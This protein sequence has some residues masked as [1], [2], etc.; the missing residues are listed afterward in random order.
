[1]EKALL[2]VKSELL[3]NRE[4]IIEMGKQVAL[5]QRAARYLLKYKNKIK[6]A[7][8]DSLKQYSHLPFQSYSIS[9][10]ND[11]M[12]MLKSSGLIQK[13][14]DKKLAIQIIKT[15]SGIKA[16]Y[17]YFHSFN[18]IKKELQDDFA[19]VP[20]I[21]RYFIES[22]V[23]DWDFLFKHLEAVALVNQISQIQ[24][25][26]AYNLLKFLFHTFIYLVV[27]FVDGINGFINRCYILIISFD[28]L[29]LWDLV[30]QRNGFQMFK[31][32]IPIG[33]VA[34]YKITFDFRNGGEVIL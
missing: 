2:L 3:I 32:K 23:T 29:Y 13:I 30:N 25:V 20:E 6:E 21:K 16:A 10:V 1:M 4:Q 24:N 11:A 9:I 27:L 12:E 33:H 19:A 7:S 8:Q 5:E 15:Y 34:F 14:N 26:E 28:I 18:T 22:N 17:E 31:E